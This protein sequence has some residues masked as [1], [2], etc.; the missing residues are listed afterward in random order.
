MEKY[1]LQEMLK[2]TREQY[3]ADKKE[4]TRLQTQAE[5]MDK[6]VIQMDNVKHLESGRKVTVGGMNA[7]HRFVIE[8]ERQS[9]AN[10]LRIK[11]ERLVFEEKE[12]KE[13]LVT[14]LSHLRRMKILKTEIEQ[15]N[16]AKA[17]YEEQHKEFLLTLQKRSKE[18]Q[19]V[20]FLFGIHHL[21]DVIDRKLAL[22]ARVVAESNRA[23]SGDAKLAQRTYEEEEVEIELRAKDSLTEFKNIMRGFR[24]L[25]QPL[26]QASV[27]SLSSTADMLN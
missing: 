17:L 7:S 20:R 27:E 12:T 26:A 15:I 3:E 16:H 21:N 25:P 22:Q 11:Q 5:A 8:K 2:K 1:T 23:F 14:Y 19:V 9:W 18:F 6:L 24:F 13:Y 4:T 10:Q